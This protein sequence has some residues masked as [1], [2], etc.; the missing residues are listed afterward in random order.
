MKILVTG[1]NGFIGSNLTRQLLSE[2][3]EVKAMVLPGTSLKNLDG[4]TCEIVYSDITKVETL[5]GKLNDVELVYHLAALPSAAWTR[6]IFKVNFQGTKNLL[7]EAI[8]CNVKRF[9]FMSSLVVHGFRNFKNA[10]EATPLMKPGILTRPYTASKIKCEELLQANKSKIE[11]VI[12]RPGF[13]IF[14]PNDLLTSKEILSRI[15]K[16]QLLAYLGSGNNRL[17]FVYVDNLVFGL[18][19]AGMESKAAGQTYII[20]D[21]DPEFIESK[22]LFPLFAE[23]LGFQAKPIAIPKALVLPIALMV[24]VLHFTFLRKKMPIFSTY[25]VQTAT[26]DLHFSSQKARSEIGFYSKT[27]LPEGLERTISWYKNLKS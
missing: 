11:V 17:G 27:K 9:V 12:I 6:T 1:A 22:N 21:H 14:G 23:K 15:E 8:R 5:Q 20:A 3:H 16:R 19:C 13:Q 26:H 24:D 7:E 25:I 10:D 4:L 2:G 18:V